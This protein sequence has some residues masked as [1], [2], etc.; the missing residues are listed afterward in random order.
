MVDPTMLHTGDSLATLLVAV[1]IPREK[2]WLVSY[3]T[4]HTAHGA[5]GFTK[6]PMAV[7]DT[8]V[9]VLQD[10]THIL[11]A[12]MVVRS[13]AQAVA[14]EA[15]RRGFSVRQVVRSRQE[16]ELLFSTKTLLL[17]EEQ[18]AKD[19]LGDWCT[20]TGQAALQD[21]RF[22]LLALRAVADSML[23]FGFESRS[24]TFVV[25]ASDPSVD[26]DARKVLERIAGRKHVLPDDMWRQFLQLDLGDGSDNC[27]Y[28][29]VPFII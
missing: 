22:E 8:A 9:K 23:R 24:M 7:P 19:D 14:F 15:Q 16:H 21:C 6:I 18:E 3:P 2:E 29:S 4:M 28:L 20:I 13:A 25:A 26:R 1:P 5:D 27:D 17:K 11:Y 10:Q 12:I